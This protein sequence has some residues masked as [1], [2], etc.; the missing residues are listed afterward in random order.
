MGWWCVSLLLFN[1]VFGE[2]VMDAAFKDA[3]DF[4]DAFEVVA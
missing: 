4:V 1:G 3:G 2:Q